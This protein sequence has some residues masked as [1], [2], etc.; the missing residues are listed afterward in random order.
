MNGLKSLKDVPKTRPTDL[1]CNIGLNKIKSLDAKSETK[2]EAKT[3]EPTRIAAKSDD[4][5]LKDMP[6]IAGNTSASLNN[7]QNKDV[8]A[9]EQLNQPR[10]TKKKSRPNKGKSA[11]LADAATDH[12]SSQDK[13]ISEL[14]IQAVLHQNPVITN[15]QSKQAQPEKQTYKITKADDESYILQG[16]ETQTTITI[17]DPKNKMKIIL[18]KRRE[19]SQLKDKLHYK[20]N[21][22]DWF[23]DQLNALGKKVNPE[24][25][26]LNNPKHKKTLAIHSFSKLVDNFIER[27]GTKSTTSGRGKYS[28][29]NETAIIIPGTLLYETGEQEC[30]LFAYLIDEDGKCFH[31]MFD[32]RNN[33]TFIRQI[34]SKG[35]LDYYEK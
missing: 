7:T 29:K 16:E 2:L 20:K 3:E 33:T 4:V 9:Q 25:P 11:G 13:T 35:C 23:E 34:S 28:D 5:E 27:H 19:E 24:N 26:D 30:G 10:K 18:Y 14:I 21:I 31:R 32:A 17:H 6:A 1:E 22:N 8:P 12:P 15:N